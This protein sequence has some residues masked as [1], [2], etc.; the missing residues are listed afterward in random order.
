MKR[1][2][3]G[4]RNTERVMKGVANHWRVEILALLND[5]PELSV[6]ELAEH[7]KTDF[8]TLAEHTRKLVH[9][10]LIMKRHDGQSVRHKVTDLGEQ[11]LKFLKTIAND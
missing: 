5:Q 3:E 11:V 1:N 10:G 8:R 4:Y 9:A 7:V 2:K 6:T